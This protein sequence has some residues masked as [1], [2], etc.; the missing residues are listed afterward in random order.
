MVVGSGTTA[1]SSTVTESGVVAGSGVAANIGTGRVWP[2]P[3]PRRVPDRS[4][5]V[6]DRRRQL[7][8]RARGSS[9]LRD[10]RARAV[11]RRGPQPDRARGRRAPAPRAGTP[12]RHRA[13]APR[14]GRPGRARARRPA[15]APSGRRPGAPVG[16]RGGASWPGAPPTFLSPPR[17]T[18]RALSRTWRPRWRGRGSRVPAGANRARPVGGGGAEDR[19]HAPPSVVRGPDARASGR[20]RPRDIAWTGDQRAREPA[21]IS[22]RRPPDG[23]PSAGGGDMAGQTTRVAR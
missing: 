23:G 21:E 12:V 6:P 9:R 14:R 1:E 20:T 22:R 17:H 11:L 15:A 16:V 13:T 3:A 10:R 19:D 2:P 5:R 7:V 18:L 4:G 8:P